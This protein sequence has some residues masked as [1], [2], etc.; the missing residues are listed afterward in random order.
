VKKIIFWGIALF[1]LIFSLGIAYVPGREEQ[2][3]SQPST[4]APEI[5]IR[6]VNDNFQ[7]IRSCRADL[8]LETNLFLFGCGSSQQQKGELMFLAP[9]NIKV[10]SNRYVFI[11]IGN[12]IKRINPEGKVEYFRFIH[13]PDFSVGFNPGL[14]SHNFYLK[15]LKAQPNEVVIEGAPKP[16]VLKNIRRVI[17]YIDPQNLLV[18]KLEM[19]FSDPSFSGQAEIKYEKIGELWV[20]TGTAGRSAIETS[21]GLLVGYSFKLSAR[22][23]RINTDITESDFK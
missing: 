20:P 17:F 1:M 18:R 13:S 5:L 14:I 11:L 22:N 15:N 19:V 16:G 10:T 9:N 21:N 12:S 7:K 6:R 8:V 23:I 4:L 3:L 2:A